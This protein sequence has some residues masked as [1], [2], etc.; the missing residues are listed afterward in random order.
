MKYY[1][2]IPKLLEFSLYAACDDVALR[3]TSGLTRQLPY[4]LYQRCIMTF[5]DKLNRNMTIKKLYDSRAQKDLDLWNIMRWASVEVR[6]S[7]IDHI[8]L[9]V[10]DTQQLSRFMTYLV[11]ASDHDVDSV[12]QCLLRW[13]SRCISSGMHE[14]MVNMMS[15]A[16]M[17]GPCRAIRQILIQYGG[18]IDP[19][20]RS[21]VT[22]AGRCGF[23]V[24]VQ[25]AVHRGGTLSPKHLL[26][27]IKS[28]DADTIVY[29]SSALGE[30][31]THEQMT[32]MEIDVRDFDV[33]LCEQLLSLHILELGQH[34]NLSNIRSVNVL[35]W[36]VDHLLVDT[37]VIF[38][39][40]VNRALYR[41][42]PWVDILHYLVEHVHATVP[43]DI[44]YRMK[45]YD[46]PD[47]DVLDYIIVHGANI[48]V[49]VDT[50]FMV[51]IS[52]VP[53][54]L[55]YWLD[56]MHSDKIALFGQNVARYFATAMV[57]DSAMAAVIIML[58]HSRFRVTKT[59]GQSLMKCAV[60]R[61]L[62]EP[63]QLL[64]KSGAS[65]DDQDS[66]GKTPLHF[67]CE[68]KDE[69]IARILLTHH[70]NVDVTDDNNTSP[71]MLACRQRH[72]EMMVLLLDVDDSTVNDGDDSGTT[73]LHVACD[74]S[75]VEIAELLIDGHG[76]DVN[77]HDVRKQTPLHLAC[78]R[79]NYDV[80]DL[81][82]KNHAK[83]NAV[84]SRGRTPL[85]LASEAGHVSIIDILLKHHVDV[86]AQDRDG[87]TPLGLACAASHRDVVARLL[88]RSDQCT[89]VNGQSVCDMANDVEI[90]KMISKYEKQHRF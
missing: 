81:L 38:P 84:T 53:G 1:I 51:K 12:I 35:Q 68:V 36:F 85:H 9:D 76:A 18:Y 43:C 78:Y 8:H 34:Y 25:H 41:G 39:G 30:A 50:Q 73:L 21:I 48:D 40:V 87:D 55:R 70:A 57:L 11:D 82:L 86:N 69:K 90:K 60:T 10:G 64:I 44:L 72:I 32:Q 58:C 24:V 59:I 47:L 89:H 45:L 26:D 83:V 5:A 3:G 63:V 62:A 2:H 61:H 33:A 13:A 37:S 28:G 17:E 46:V 27:A 66:D 65:V 7:V 6:V 42:H 4:V 49:I 14:L 31:H 20:D 15:A 74:N 52:R 56:R 23:A 75:D 88:T 67:A 19:S 29:I 80:V 54:L 16:L 79:G 77:V 22:V 71:L